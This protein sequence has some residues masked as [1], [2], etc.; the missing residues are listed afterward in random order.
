MDIATTIFDMAMYSTCIRCEE[1]WST[2]VTSA[3]PFYKL[4][5][6]DTETPFLSAENCINRMFLYDCNTSASFKNPLNVISLV[7]LSIFTMECMLRLYSWRLNMFTNWLDVAAFLVLLFYPSITLKSEMIK[8][9]Y[10]INKVDQPFS[11]NLD[12]NKY[13]PMRCRWWWHQS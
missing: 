7:I 6:L 11:Q 12:L 2:D 8:R 5:E 10:R 4:S 13:V 9:Q 1:E 3:N